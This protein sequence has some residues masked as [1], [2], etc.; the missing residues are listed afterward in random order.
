ML[1]YP[2]QTHETS[3]NPNRSSLQRHRKDEHHYDDDLDDNDVDDSTAEAAFTM[4]KL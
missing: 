1:S 2:L 3:W 4:M